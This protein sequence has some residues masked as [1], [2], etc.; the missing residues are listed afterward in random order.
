MAGSITLRLFLLG[1]FASQAMASCAYGTLL[2]PRAEG[3]VEV[4]TFGYTGKTVCILVW[5]QRE[6]ADSYDRA[7][8][9]GSS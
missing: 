6:Y 1:A 8:P 9:A 7:L 2:H 4:N 3:K 5:T